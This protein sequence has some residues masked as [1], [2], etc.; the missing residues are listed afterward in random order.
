MD[1]EAGGGLYQ[2][3]GAP[4][5]K[6]VRVDHLLVGRVGVNALRLKAFGLSL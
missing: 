1:S 4:A 6:M 5:S 3:L 2:T